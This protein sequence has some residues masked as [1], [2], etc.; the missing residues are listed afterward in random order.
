MREITRNGAKF[1]DGKEKEFDSIIFA[2]GYKSNV[3]SWLKVSMTHFYFLHM[4][5]LPLLLS[6][7]QSCI[8]FNLCNTCRRLQNPSFFPLQ[9]EENQLGLF[10]LLSTPKKIK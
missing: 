6:Y 3:P 2:T 4:I 1:V 10:G 5:F 7:S 8:T 9:K